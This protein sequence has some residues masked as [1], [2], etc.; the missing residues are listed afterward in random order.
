MY[1]VDAYRLLDDRAFLQNRASLKFEELQDLDLKLQ[2]LR[3]EQRGLV[4]WPEQFKGLPRRFE[5]WNAR[6]KSQE[7]GKVPKYRP[8][9]RSSVP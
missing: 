1:G 8:L 9:D 6:I 2:N 7:A 3:N 5:E 4:G